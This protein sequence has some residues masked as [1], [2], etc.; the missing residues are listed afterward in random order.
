MDINTTNVDLLQVNSEKFKDLK[1]NNL[2]DA[3]IRQV[4][5][6]FEAFFMQQIMEISLKSNKIAG[7]A[8]G[9]D[10]IKGMYTQT[11]SKETAG[12]LG[13]SDMLYKFL[14]ENNR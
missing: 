7:E 3:R 12:S 11:L 1:T 9:A 4:A 10:I 2:E 5:N 6:D 14:S 13:I 8:P